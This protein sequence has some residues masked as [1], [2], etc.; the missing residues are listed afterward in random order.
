MQVAG[1]VRVSTGEQQASGLGRLR[2]LSGQATPPPKELPR[3][4]HRAV[5]EK[6]GSASDRTRTGDLR[7]DRPAF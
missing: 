7:R 6:R 3:G 1:Y 4:E 2:P 5:R